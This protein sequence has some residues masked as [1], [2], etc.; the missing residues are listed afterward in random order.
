MPLHHSSYP[1]PMDKLEDEIKFLTAA[2][3]HMGFKEMLRPVPGVVG[4]G[5]QKPYFWISGI[6]ND[7][8]PLKA[9]DMEKRITH[10]YAFSATGLLP[11][12][13]IHSGL[14]FLGFT[15]ADVAFMDRRGQAS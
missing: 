15:T 13:F 4:L 6:G 12:M 7:R 8:Q 2:L 5:E 11:D 3:G 9:E 1:V 14:S 10:H